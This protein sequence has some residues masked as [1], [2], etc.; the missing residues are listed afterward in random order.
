MA[1]YCATFT[2]E[3]VPVV[4]GGCLG[5]KGKWVPELQMIDGYSDGFLILRKEDRRMASAFGKVCSEPRPFGT[6]S[7]HIFNHIAQLQGAKVDA[8]IRTH[9]IGNE[10]MVDVRIDGIQIKG[11]YK[12]FH[13]VIDITVATITTP[14]GTRVPDMV[15]SVVSTPRRGVNHL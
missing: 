7:A 5:P 15:L 6:N 2:M 10:A 12:K 11:R 1:K 3:S 4:S 9:V 8:I 14:V 13:E